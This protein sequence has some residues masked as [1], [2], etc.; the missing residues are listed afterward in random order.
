M[1]TCLV[2][3]SHYYGQFAFFPGKE[4][5]YVS[6]KLNPLNT[7]S[8]LIQKLSMAPSVSMLVGFD[9]STVVTKMLRHEHES[10]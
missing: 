7:D 9:G 5:P 6:S 8:P 1:D 2:W 4:S 3:T 10:H